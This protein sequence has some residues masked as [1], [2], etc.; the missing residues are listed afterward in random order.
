[1]GGYIIYLA[2]QN[3]VDMVGAY[4]SWQVFHYLE[5]KQQSFLLTL[6]F[7]MEDEP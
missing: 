7:Q 6:H 3:C 1:M 4:F 5:K 2:L